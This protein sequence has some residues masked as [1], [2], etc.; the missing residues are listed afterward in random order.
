MSARGRTSACGVLEVRRKCG[1]GAE[2]KASK[3]STAPA[4]ERRAGQRA[5]GT[6]S[7]HARRQ[8]KIYRTDSRVQRK[9]LVRDVL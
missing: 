5:A 2:K 4:D 7:H 8:L 9:L 1:H 6:H 3:L